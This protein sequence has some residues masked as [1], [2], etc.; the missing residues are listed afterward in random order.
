LPTAYSGNITTVR[1]YGLWSNFPLRAPCGIW[2]SQ[3]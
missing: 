1:T 2:A 3:Q